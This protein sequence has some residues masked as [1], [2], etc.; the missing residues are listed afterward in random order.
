MLGN[1]TELVLFASSY[2]KFILN[3]MR[4]P[5]AIL[6]VKHG[7]GQ[8]SPFM[9]A[10]SSCASC[11]QCTAFSLHRVH[12]QCK[13]SSVTKSSFDLTRVL[14]G[15]FIVAQLTKESPD[16]HVIQMFPLSFSQNRAAGS[17]LEA[18]DYSP[19]SYTILTIHYFYCYCSYCKEEGYVCVT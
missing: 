8:I 1:W 11:K 16:F 9:Y 6:D 10:F 2:I 13:L 3:F 7:N 12:E 14:L 5:S 17:S 19:H 4:I 15:D 18:C